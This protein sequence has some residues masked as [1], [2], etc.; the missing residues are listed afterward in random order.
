[1]NNNK[2]KLFYKG[3]TIQFDNYVNYN[4]YNDST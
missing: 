2:N 1:M 3:D 4:I